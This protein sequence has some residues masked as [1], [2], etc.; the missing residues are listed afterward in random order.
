MSSLFSTGM[1]IVC[2]IVFDLDTMD[3]TCS[4]VLTKKKKYVQSLR[5]Q[6]SSCTEPIGPGRKLVSTAA[7][8]VPL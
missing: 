6:K 7:K 4:R 3:E 5:Q 8:F 1:E 2:G